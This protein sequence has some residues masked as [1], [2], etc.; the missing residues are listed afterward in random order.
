MW[1]VKHFGLREPAEI[2]KK[3][4]ELVVDFM[5]EHDRGLYELGMDIAICSIDEKNQTLK[6][7][8]AK[9]PLYVICDELD[10]STGASVKKYT[11]KTR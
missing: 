6:Y 7:A 10:I 3:V 8:G 4:N 5:K 11:Q 1:A 2:L 9:R